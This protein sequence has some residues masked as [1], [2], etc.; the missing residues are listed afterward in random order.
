M[1][2][3]DKKKIS[4]FKKNGFL[5]IPNFFSKKDEDI[6]YKIIKKF[7]YNQLFSYKINLKL[8]NNKKTFLQKN[9]ISIEKK[10]KII[11]HNLYET[12]HATPYFIN[13]FYSK[14]IIRLATK[15]MNCDKNALFCTS[16]RLRIDPPGDRPYRLKWHQEARYS[17]SRQINGI[18]YWSPFFFD[19][20]LTNGTIQVYA[21]SHTKGIFS[22]GKNT[23]KNKKFTSD[24]FFIDEKFLSKKFK[25]ITIN[26]KNRSLVVFSTG[27]VHRSCDPKIQKKM[28]YSF[29]SRF[30]NINS[31]NFSPSY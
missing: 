27:L 26:C 19:A 10:K 15:F 5:I 1:I 18:Q 16:Q 4:F 17:K 25:K 29:I 8:S 9:L 14:S 24:N 23:N 30:E 21:G 13:L 6:I 31:P 11:I 20:S 12:L 22:V 7:I 28:K 2:N 3:I